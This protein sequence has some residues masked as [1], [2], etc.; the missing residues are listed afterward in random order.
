MPMQMNSSV[1]EPV[2]LCNRIVK[3][4][5]PV[6]LVFQLSVFLYPG[7]QRLIKLL[8]LNKTVMISPNQIFSP[9]QLFQR[10]LR[11]D[12]AFHRYIPQNI[13]LILWTNF[14]IPICDQSLIH[15]IYILI[16]TGSQLYNII[17]IKMQIGCKIQHIIP[18]FLFYSFRKRYPYTEAAPDTVPYYSNVTVFSISLPLRFTVMVTSSFT[19]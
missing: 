9:L 7:K 15:L 3:Q 16:G 13:H 19:L 4:D 5:K 10:L 2:P 17:M 14:F 12:I 18:T 1:I 11:I 8:L 6:A